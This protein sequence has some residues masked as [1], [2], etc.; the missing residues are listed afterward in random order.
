[1]LSFFTPAF[2]PTT[3]PPENFAL[4]SN[5]SGLVLLLKEDNAECQR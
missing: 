1:M 5:Q 3:E 2:R 4:F